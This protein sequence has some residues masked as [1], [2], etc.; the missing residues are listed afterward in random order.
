MR[1]FGCGSQAGGH[2]KVLVLLRGL[3]LQLKPHKPRDDI[4]QGC[5]EKQNQEDM[6]IYTKRKVD[7]NALAHS[8]VEM[9]KFK[10]CRAGR[11]GRPPRKNCGSRPSE[12]CLGTEFPPLGESPSFFF[13]DIN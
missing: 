6:S 10:V 5:P 3:C 1:P 8:I 4:S 11:L 9:A 13:M 7:L 12:G 2:V